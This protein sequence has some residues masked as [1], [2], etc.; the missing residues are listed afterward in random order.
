MDPSFRWK[1][2]GAVAQMTRDVCQ[3]IRATTGLETVA[4]SGGVYQNRLLLRI[5]RALLRT[6]DFE[7][8]VHEKVPPNDGGL[9]LGQAAIVAC[10]A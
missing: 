8:L 7:V 6:A 10:G 3:Q 1:C 5:T 2:C 9:A 4:L